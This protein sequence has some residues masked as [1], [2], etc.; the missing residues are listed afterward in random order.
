M[1]KCIR[2]S[3]FILGIIT[4]IIFVLF[5]SYNFGVFAL[6]FFF[7]NNIIYCC[8]NIK[9]R[10]VLFVFHVTTFVFLISR[11]VIEMFRDSGWYK[12]YL[13]DY[14]KASLDFSF[15]SIIISLLGLFF[16]GL[17]AERVQRQRTENQIRT[18]AALKQEKKQEFSTEFRNNI[19]KISLIIFYISMSA[20]LLLEL[21]KLWFMRG[22]DYVEYY[23]SFVSQAPYLIHLIASFMK[24]SLCIYLASLPKKEESY[25]PLGLYLLSAFPSL[26]IGIRN[27]IMQNGIFIVLYFFLRD[28]LG[29]KKKWLGKIE[30]TVIA[31]GLP[32][33]LIFMG[34]YS[35]IRAHTA[36]AVHG[37]GNL[38]VSFFYG[39]G[40]TFQVLNIGYGCIDQL[41]VRSFRNYTFGGVIDYF[42]HGTFAQ[43][44]FGA[45][46]LDNTNSIENALYSNNF[47]HNMSYIAKGEDYL[48]GQGWGSSYILETYVDFGYIGV[49]IFSIL[50]AVLLVFIVKMMKKIIFLRMIGL[51][52]LTQVF[53]VPRA[54]AT[55]FL[56]FLF[57]MQFWAA[58]AVCFMGAALCCKKYEFVQKKEE[59]NV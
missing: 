49:A 19:R 32:F 20:T 29:D 37:I 35:S 13:D 36:N 3:S 31:V 22:R 18:S 6:I 30:K 48:N 23:T 52:I 11:P 34:M 21:E 55:G 40:V 28:V 1:S 46:P 45:R 26:L 14:G 38:L 9:N 53:F 42:A 17:L 47:S 51:L 12:T 56:N 50:M 43:L 58:V 54:E 27:P 8:E 41:P 39:Q 5:E 4:S 16:G 10:I 7:V 2:Y 33:V 59:S 57:Q 15:Y 25:V 24:F 44:F